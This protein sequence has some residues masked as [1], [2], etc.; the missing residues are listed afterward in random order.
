MIE[1]QQQSFVPIEESE[2]KKIVVSKCGD[3]PQNDVD[4]A[5]PAMS[6]CPCHLRT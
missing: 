4:D 5:K 1:M 2:T 6:L 3:R